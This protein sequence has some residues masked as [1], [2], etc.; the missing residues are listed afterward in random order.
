MNE[1][2]QRGPRAKAPKGMTSRRVNMP[3][4]PEELLELKY[5]AACQ[6]RSADSMARLIYLEGL[7][8]LR[9]REPIPTPS[10]YG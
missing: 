4:T 7:A 9:L 1:A 6:S 10:P 8:A 3:L 2:L 5:R